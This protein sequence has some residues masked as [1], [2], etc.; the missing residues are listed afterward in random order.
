MNSDVEIVFREE[1]NGFISYKLSDV[2]QVNCIAYNTLGRSFA[3]LIFACCKIT[4][5]LSIKLY[6]AERKYVTV[7]EK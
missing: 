4:R 2:L 3:A 7:K 1:K 5:I 6:Q